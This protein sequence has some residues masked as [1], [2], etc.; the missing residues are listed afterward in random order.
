MTEP[1]R[2]LLRRAAVTA[3]A[4]ACHTTAVPA[5]GVPALLLSDGPNGIRGARFDERDIGVVTPCGSAMAATWD[6][7]LIER[8]GRLIGDQARERNVDVVL[9]PMMNI[10]RSPLG[11]RAFECFSEDPLL[12]GVLASAW[13]AGVQERG[14]AACPKHLVAND[15]DTGRTR[16]DCRV[17]ERALREIYLLPFEHALRSGA[18]AVMAAY[19][20]VNGIRSTEHAQLLTDVLRREWGWDG[21]VVSDW[22]AARDTEACAEAG[23]DLEMPGPARVFGPALARAVAAGRL[24]AGVLEEK[25]ERVQRLAAWCARGPRRGAAG[26][27]EKAPRELL[28]QASAAA[29]VLLKNQDALLPLAPERVRRLAVI[30]PNAADPCW[31]GGGSCHVAMEERPTPVAAIAARYAGART[32]HEPGCIHRAVVPLHLLDVRPPEAPRGRGVTVEYFASEDAA[33]SPEAREVRRGSRFVWMSSAADDGWRA[34][35][36]SS[37]FTPAASGAHTFALRASGAARLSIDGRHVV[38]M[39]MRREDGALMGALFSKDEARA[40]IELAAGVP[41]RLEILMRATDHAMQLL[42]FGCRPPDDPTALS[43]AAAAAAAADAAV[44]VVGTSDQVEAES[45]DRTTIRLPGAQDELVRQVIAANPATVVVVNAG[46]SVAMPWARAARAVIQAWLPGQ[47]FGTALGAVL[48]GDLEPGGRLPVTLARNALDYPA[49]DT[50]PDASGRLHYRES[51]FVGYRHFDAHGIA[52]EF[53]FG[54]GLTYTR[55]E[56]ERLELLPPTSG[57]REPLRAR[58]RVR[59]TGPRP[60]KEVVQ[61]YVADLDA[62]VARPPAELR[63]FAAVQLASGEARSV[64]LELDRRAFSYWDTDA[65]AWRVDAGRFEIRVGRS[66]RDIRLTASIRV[67]ADLISPDDG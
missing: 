55:F 22:F 41:V 45:R 48:S 6:A 31:Q 63:A 38:S 5:L 13:V 40:S 11:A 33:G 16:V 7:G 43:R 52:P 61:L 49:L 1:S 66:S 42:Q 21:V 27:A 64:Q 50:S 10:P 24:D 53:A 51:V 37:V 28:R 47:E 54:H 57:T 2:Q 58:V 65:G 19:N 36:V 3:G 26:T 14:V 9:G 15:A 56:F 32:V 62:R 17:D 23:L 30:G 12:S 18:R 46:A 34:V 4:D 67:G 29:F 8:I 60:G 39:S 59:N 20:A 25:A 44:V 35:R